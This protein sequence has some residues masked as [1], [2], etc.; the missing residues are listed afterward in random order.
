MLDQDTRAPF[1]IPYISY[2]D[3]PDRFVGKT[4]RMP[5]S[6]LPSQYVSRTRLLWSIISIA[7]NSDQLL[8]H[9]HLNFSQKR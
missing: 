2:R 7:A 5:K 9:L 3:S 6:F 8:N 4:I 1:C